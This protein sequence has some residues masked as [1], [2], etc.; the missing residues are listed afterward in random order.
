MKNYLRHERSIEGTV[1]CQDGVAE[2]VTQRLPR[3]APF[4]RDATR[5]VVGVNDG[6]SKFSQPISDGR[7]PRTNPARYSNNSHY[8]TVLRACDTR[9][10]RAL[11]C[12]NTVTVV[13][14]CPRES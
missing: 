12:S 14:Y 2:G 13:G 11:G 4:A 1:T 3:W 8:S 9:D 10:V 5:H 6:I 7:L